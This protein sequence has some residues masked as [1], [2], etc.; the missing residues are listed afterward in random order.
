LTN[1]PTQHHPW[2]RREDE[3]I[4]FLRPKRIT[5]PTTTT[6]GC[7]VKISLYTPSVPKRM[8]F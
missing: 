2:V 1:P 4:Y 5:R 7:A 6:S 3:C 8:T